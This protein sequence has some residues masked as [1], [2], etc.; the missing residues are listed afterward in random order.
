MHD[1]TATEEY[2]EELTQRAPQANDAR[3][4]K[5]ICEGAGRKSEKS[6]KRVRFKE[7]HTIH[8]IPPTRNLNCNINRDIAAGTINGGYDLFHEDPD[9]LW[10]YEQLRCSCLAVE[11][12]IFTFR[13]TEIGRE[14][15]E[16]REANAAETE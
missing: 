12:T 3:T 4:T 2:L 5:E 11:K 13:K 7:G 15:M 9:L 14:F 10:L 1:S 8:Y 16:S 6:R